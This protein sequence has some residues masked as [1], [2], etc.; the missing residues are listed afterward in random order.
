MKTGKLR[1]REDERFEIINSKGEYITYLT[2]GDPVELYDEN[3]ERWIQGRI[4]HE[5]DEGYYFLSNND[6]AISIYENDKVRVK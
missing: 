1:L 5:W 3:E 2:S 6:N 4:E